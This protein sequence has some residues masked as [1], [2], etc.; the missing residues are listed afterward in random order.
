MVDDVIDRLNDANAKVRA[1][2]RGVRAELARLRDR[3]RR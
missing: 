2:M 1:E 3:K